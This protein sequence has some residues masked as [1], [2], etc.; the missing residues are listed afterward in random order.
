MKLLIWG[1]GALGQILLDS[2]ARLP[3]CDEIAWLVDDQPAG[4]R[5]AG[6]SVW[7]DRRQLAQAAA[8]GWQLAV[9]LGRPA[10]RFH[11]L[12][13]AAAAGLELATLIDPLALVSPRAE[14]GPG[15]LVLPGA[16][17]NAGAVLGPGVLVHNQVLISHH[18]RIERAV[19]LY[20]GARVLGGGRIG[21]GA[22]IGAGAAI[23]A[24]AAIGDW[25]RVASMA[26]VF[27]PVAERTLVAGNPARVLQQLP[28]ADQPG[29]LELS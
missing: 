12:A 28:D 20:P 21:T 7:G 22:Q 16:I 14:L 5:I 2:F 15:C 9:A 18:A 29:W 24:E 11:A 4:S 6:L 10:H 1:A 19:S 13:L 8:E 3:A 27:H 23:L 26:A 17:I 25:S